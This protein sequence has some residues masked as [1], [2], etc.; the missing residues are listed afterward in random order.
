MYLQWVTVYSPR[1]AIKQRCFY[2]L[3]RYEVEKNVR[4]GAY[5]GLFLSTV[6][7]CKHQWTLVL[8]D[9]TGFTSQVRQRLRCKI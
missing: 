9:G 5:D 1:R 8:D 6:A 7:C 2:N 3:A 4:E